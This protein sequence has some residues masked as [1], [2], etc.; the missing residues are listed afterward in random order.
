[1]NAVLGARELWGFLLDIIEPSLLAVLRN[2]DR[3]KSNV[4]NTCDAVAALIVGLREVAHLFLLQRMLLLLLLVW[5]N[6][7]AYLC[8]TV[9][10]LTRVHMRKCS[11][12]SYTFTSKNHAETSRNKILTYSSRSYIWVYGPTIH[13]L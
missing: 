2:K 8:K 9:A 1:V 4:E 11:F 6:F 10:V 13:S 3:V 7:L 12:L 5:F